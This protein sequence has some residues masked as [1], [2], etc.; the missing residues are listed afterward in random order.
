MSVFMILSLSSCKN[1]SSNE[2]ND[3]IE[4][5]GNDNEEEI[6][7][8]TLATP[9]ITLDGNVV[10]WSAVE[11]A[12]GYTVL[13][14]DINCGT[15]ETLNY[16]ITDTEVGDYV[17]KVMAIS[18]DSTRYN[19]SL[20]SATVTYTVEPIIELNEATLY[21]VGDSTVSSF[22]DA[23][24]YPRYGYGTQLNNYLDSKITVK[25]LALSGRSS[26]SFLGESNYNI[27]KNEIKK[28]DYLAIGFGHND[29]KSDDET[30]FTNAS[31]PTTDSNSFKYSLYENYCK[32]AIEKEATPILCTPIVRLNSSNDYSGA[33]GHNYTNSGIGDYSQAIRQLGEEKSIAVIDL[34]N[35]TKTEYE[36]LGYN[37]A[38]YYHAMTKAIS[39][40]NGKT[41]EPDLTS[42][43]ATHIN[44]FGAKFVA[45][46]FANLLS[47]TTCNLKSYVKNNIVKPTKGIDLVAND[48]TYIYTA[49][50]AP[51]LKTYQPEPSFKTT[52]EGFYGTAFGTLGGA[53]ISKGFVA[54]ESSLGVYEVGQSETSGK[55]SSSADG[56]GFVFKQVSIND[57]F[58]LKA[59]ATVSTFK[60]S[61]QAGFGLML[62]DDC[63]INQKANGSIATNFVCA[64]FL[65]T[66]TEKM[67]SIFSRSSASTL[68][69]SNYQNIDLYGLNSTADFEI[70]RLGQVVTCVVKY[71]NITYTQTYTDFDFVEIDSNYMYVGMYATRGTIATF[72]NVIYTYTGE[73][74]GA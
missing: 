33:S 3:D 71:N 69:K 45:Y 40:D 43:D 28:G 56:F 46:S 5:N 74:Q 8:V 15:Q 2:K 24:F 57:N 36:K 42:V 49:Y 62:R 47:S 39:N 13:K 38:I 44:I 68:T 73:S 70:T 60:A 6:T 37:E 67:T 35:A 32:L 63:Y 22:S 9:T 58:I 41:L 54:K 29:E 27:L 34:T 53:P 23:Y 21:V 65:A 20:Y 7:K 59:S 66:S 19:N 55:F 14:N 64:G 61:N 12:T 1:E 51:N 18:S 16:T 11:H 17:I 30:R 10:S 26:K 31:L 48:K 4:D 25:N 72:T 52:T 50:S